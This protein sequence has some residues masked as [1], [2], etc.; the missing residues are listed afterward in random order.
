RTYWHWDGQWWKELHWSGKPRPRRYALPGRHCTA[1]WGTGRWSAA[2][3]SVACDKIASNFHLNTISPDHF[4]PDICHAKDVSAG[5]IA[6]RQHPSGSTCTST[7]Q[8]HQQRS[9]QT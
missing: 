6:D 4:P 5:R 7:R 1:T 2:T 9:G 8:Y 3:S